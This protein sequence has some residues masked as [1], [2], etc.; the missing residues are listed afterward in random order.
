MN[1]KEIKET[2]CSCCG[3]GISSQTIEYLHT[4]GHWNE[5][6]TFECG[7]KLHFSP[8]FME[9]VVEKECPKN[10][11]EVIKN[12]KR[13]KF[14]NKLIDFILDYKL[15]DLAEKDKVLKALEYTL[16]VN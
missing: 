11:K 9:V 2:T 13:K 15:V 16:K 12:N 7:R 8:N 1:L 10:K 14:A 3:R 5:R 6:I 4:N